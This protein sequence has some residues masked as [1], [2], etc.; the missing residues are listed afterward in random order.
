MNEITVEINK[1]GDPVITV[2]E[3][4]VILLIIFDKPENDNENNNESNNESNNENNNES[5]NGN[6][7]DSDKDKE[8]PVREPVKNREAEPK[9]EIERKRDCS[10]LYC[11]PDE[12]PEEMPLGKALDRLFEKRGK[13]KIA[14][15]P[16][17]DTLFIVYDEEQIISFDG[18]KY[19]PAPLAVIKIE[20]ETAADISYA[21][22]ETAADYLNDITFMLRDK[23]GVDFAYRL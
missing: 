12:I 10:V 11:V 9:S 15:I 17:S 16:G 3:D 19:L 5:N 13:V 4:E 1:T 8:T 22:F 20:N 23:N 21:D 6:D 14:E 2:G 7:S 18:G